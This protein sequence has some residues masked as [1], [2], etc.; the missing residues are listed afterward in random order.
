MDFYYSHCVLDHYAAKLINLGLSE[1]EIYRLSGFNLSRKNINPFFGKYNSNKAHKIFDVLNEFSYYS[2]NEIAD[3]TTLDL[4][5]NIIGAHIMNSPTLGDLINGAIRCSNLFKTNTVINMNLDSQ[6]LKIFHTY[7]N[8]EKNFNTAQG[9]LA[10]IAHCIKKYMSEHEITIETDFSSARIP[11]RD[12]YEGLIGGPIRYN[13]DISC[14]KIPIKF[15]DFRSP[16]Y[17]PFAHRYLQKEID[18]KYLA[19]QSSHHDGFIQQISKLLESGDISTNAALNMNDLTHHLN[20]SRSS[21]YRNLEQRGLSFRALMED[22][23]KQLAIKML[24]RDKMKIYQISDA[25]GYSNTS[26]FTRAFTKWYGVTPT[27]MKGT[28]DS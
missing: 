13:K 24:M 28:A 5:S 25:L 12:G 19:H 3:I 10:R 14:I 26:A 8:E 21:I 7:L 23:K 9:G 22:R 4:S 2:H 11:D 17:N 27:H 18:E 6:H 16:Q 15:M 1:G 20:M